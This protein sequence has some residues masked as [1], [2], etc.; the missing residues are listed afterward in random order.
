ML[1]IYLL[2]PTHIYVCVLLGGG[3]G[4]G[5]GAKFHSCENTFQNKFSMGDTPVAKHNLTLLNNP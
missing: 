4:R 2:P 3:G 5:G 1:Y